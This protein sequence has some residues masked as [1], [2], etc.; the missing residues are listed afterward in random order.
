M[1]HNTN[2]ID[3]ET[4]S[5]A[6]SHWING[7]DAEAC[8]LLSQIQTEYARNLL[9]LIRKPHITVLAQLPWMTKGPQGILSGSESDSKFIINNIGFKAGD[10]QVS[11]Y[12]NVHDFYNPAAP[13]DFYIAQMLEWHPI[14]PNIQTLPCP[15]FAQTSDY[16]LHIQAIHP[17]LRLFDELIVNGPEEQDEVARLSGKPVSFFPKTFSIPDSLVP[18]PNR[19]NREIDFFMS[20]TVFH[21]FHTD[22]AELINHILQLQDL[23]TIIYN[24]YINQDAYY[25]L[26]TRSK[27][28]LSFVRHADAMPTRGLETLA[29]GCALL[30]QQESVL[31]Q[32]LSEEHGVVTYDYRNPDSIK[33]AIQKVRTNWEYFEVAARKGS[34]L[35]R[36]EFTVARIAS[37]F[38]RFLTVL[39]AKPRAARIIG[40]DSFLDQ[41]RNI[42][43]K[44]WK[45]PLEFNNKLQHI[46]LDRWASRMGQI[47]AVEPI[48]EIGRELTL[49]LT[50][51]SYWPVARQYPIMDHPKDVAD[52]SRLVHVLDTGIRHFP[53]SM[54]LAF[55][56]A[57]SAL[58]FGMSSHVTWA[59]NLMRQLVSRP[60]HSWRV[61]P[62]HDVMPWDFFSQTFNY[63]GYFDEVMELLK[64]TGGDNNN[65]KRFIMAS[66]HYYLSFYE[67]KLQHL[68]QA[69]GLDPG[70]DFYTYRFVHT[71][72]KQHDSSRYEMAA[73]DAVR[74][75]DISML[76]R[77][78]FALVKCFVERGISVP[79]FERLQQ[80]CKTADIDIFTQAMEIENWLDPF[81]RKAVTDYASAGSKA[82]NPA[83]PAEK[84]ILFIHLDFLT[85]KS[86]RTWSF[87]SNLAMVDALRQLGHD[88]TV[89]PAIHN[90]SPRYPA[91]WLYRIK[92]ICSQVAFDQ[93]WIE[94][95]H[96]DPEESFL[97]FLAA[98]IP[99]RVA[100]LPESLEYDDTDY[101]MSPSL[102]Q[103]RML[104]ERKLRFMTHA[105][106]V[107]EQ[108][109]DLLNKIGVVKSLWKPEAVPARFVSDPHGERLNQIV[110]MGNDSG[111][112]RRWLEFPSLAKLIMRRPSPDDAAPLPQLFNAVNGLVSCCLD[113]G[114]PYRPE[115]LS[116]YLDA[117]YTIRLESYSNWMKSLREVGAVVNLP[118]ATKAY[119]N[120]V[121]ESMAAGCA[122]FSWRIA[123][124][125]AQEKLF[126]KDK[127]ILFDADN[128]QNL[129]DITGKTTPEQL[130][131]IGRAAQREIS[132]AHTT[133]I[134]MQQVLTWIDTGLTPDYAHPPEPSL[135][136]SL[137]KA[138]N[139]RLAVDTL[140]SCMTGKKA[141]GHLWLKRAPQR[142]DIENGEEAAFVNAIQ[143]VYNEGDKYTARRLLEE[144]IDIFPEF[145]V[146]LSQWCV[147]FG[148]MQIA[149]QN[150]LLA[151]TANPYSSVALLNAF[152]MAVKAGHSEAAKRFMDDALLYNSSA[153]NLNLNELVMKRK[154]MHT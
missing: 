120:R 12:A 71:V 110:F 25:D 139:L 128:P 97:D 116:A 11:P 123:G 64:G 152:E 8:C 121:F 60:L 91:S 27:L 66:A 150:A 125:N 99:V 149:M 133:E 92:E 113:D 62:L 137:P 85:W 33:H 43:V 144:L 95:V 75:A 94:L 52:I 34:E 46:N 70:F 73:R 96:L 48:I 93:V 16:D 35:V 1:T 68:E 98:T 106:A 55:N 131:E 37:Q 84:K 87:S 127:I 118:G 69:I 74:L 56:A 45:Y 129:I 36:R 79:E 112:R 9:A 130:R 10:M 31:N 54:V 115:Q 3:E 89:I 30:V 105:L 100:L 126:D 138:A 42:L 143:E 2:T 147:E 103:R 114:R 53:E 59:L 145:S 22:K 41:K 32:Y 58:H 4:F 78:A 108:D 51:H 57:R 44:G 76:F 107:D 104:V 109:A 81:L 72:I 83:T 140:Y 28:S 61:E 14:P 151:I 88:V 82:P 63:R 142:T 29:M 77:E 24:G 38:L 148:D 132:R 7:N 146:T 65:L 13:P 17:W 119:G 117:L 23:N 47:A 122:V 135:P 86:A 124:R 19:G 26:L 49:N 111:V 90:I 5:C 141:P 18:I 153:S 136:R 20:G 40:S 154:A 80:K 67:N 101:A 39:A 134:R 6:V 21:P 15:I 50:L 102:R